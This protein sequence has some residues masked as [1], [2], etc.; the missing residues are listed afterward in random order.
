DSWRVKPNLTVSYGL[1]HSFFRQPTDALG[2]LENFD[3]SR[4]DP[5]KAPCITSTGAPDVT[6]SP[7]GVLTSACN[8]NFD[9]LNGYIFVHP[10]AGVNGHKSPYGDKVGKEFN[11]AIA[12]RLGIAWDPWGDG[13]TSVRAGFGL[14]FDSGL[15]YGNAEN[16][17]FTGIG[18]QNP[19]SFSNVTFANPTGGAPVPATGIP[20]AATALQS[21]IDPN[22]VSPYSQQWSLDIQR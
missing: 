21:R 15:I 2:L 19:L 20:G 7:A 3:P 22:Y 1:R 9:P 16:D 6:K 5:A 11:L 10:P 14:F 18:F 4:W 17:I 12:P 8:P 13:K